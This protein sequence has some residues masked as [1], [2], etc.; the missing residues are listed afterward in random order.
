MIDA[1]TECAALQAAEAF[2]PLVIW[3]GTFRT[4][5]KAVEAK[6]ELEL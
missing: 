6:I 1:V 2:K 3:I 5:I 4:F